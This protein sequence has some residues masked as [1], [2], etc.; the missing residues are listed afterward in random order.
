MLKKAKSMLLGCTTASLPENPTFDDAI[1]YNKLS[2]RILI[3]GPE[4]GKSSLCNALLQYASLRNDPSSI[5]QTSP[6]LSIQSSVIE[7]PKSL[8]KSSD[9]QA[10]YLK[11]LL[12]NNTKKQAKLSSANS[13][14]LLEVPM[15][16]IDDLADLLPVHGAILV[17]SGVADSEAMKIL[18]ATIK[19]LYSQTNP[20][21]VLLLANIDEA[22]RLDERRSFAGFLAEL[23]I[24]LSLC[25]S[26]IPMAN[27]IEISEICLNSGKGFEKVVDFLRRCKFYRKL[28]KNEYQNSEETMNLEALRELLKPSPATRPPTPMPASKKANQ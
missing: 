17:Y 26:P 4:C 15:K 14:N 5:F 13:F 2:N 10:I 1:I 8:L 11:S 20:P 16:N 21:P 18:Y 22:E 12:E 7:L 27:R 25:K 3:V 6:T 19:A 24:L 23:Q 9:C 28:Y